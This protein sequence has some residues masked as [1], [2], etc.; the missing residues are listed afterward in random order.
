M[1]ET[2]FVPTARLKWPAASTGLHWSPDARGRRY[3]EVVHGPKPGD[4]YVRVSVH[5][6]HRWS[7]PIRQGARLLAGL[8]PMA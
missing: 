7:W 6:H 8:C 2:R 1:L 5:R 3:P 4:E